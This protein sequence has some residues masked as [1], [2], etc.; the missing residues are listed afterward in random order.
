VYAIVIEPRIIIATYGM[1][2]MAV[3]NGEYLC[4]VNCE[5]RVVKK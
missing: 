2:A 4:I 5:L 3:F 1:F